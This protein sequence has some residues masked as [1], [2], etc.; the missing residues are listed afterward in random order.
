MLDVAL[1][2]A[3]AA[4]TPTLTIESPADGTSTSARTIAIEGTAPAPPRGGELAITVKVNGRPVGVDP[5]DTKFRIP[6]AIAVGPNDIDVLAEVYG[7]D[8]LDPMATATGHLTLTRVPIP[9]DKTGVLDA[10]TAY[11]VADAQP[12]IYELCYEACAA[13]P[14]CF[15][16]GPRRVDCPVSVPRVSDGRVSVRRATC[17][18]V[19][20]VRLRG[21]EIYVGEYACNG[22]FRPHPRR[23]IRPEVYRRGHRFRVASTIDEIYLEEFDA[24]NRYGVPRFDATTNLFIP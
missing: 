1:A 7:P 12:D 16:L 15:A 23:F 9:G 14:Y 18:L 19:M 20:T 17:G 8:S 10:A 21:R 5:A 6:V 3:L 24:A 13:E 4:V 11:A 2:I 22:R